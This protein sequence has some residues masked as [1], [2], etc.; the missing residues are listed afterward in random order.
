MLEQDFPWCGA[1]PDNPSS[2]SVSKPSNLIGFPKLEQCFGLSWTTSKERMP[3]Y[4]SQGK[5]SRSEPKDD[6][7][8]SRKTSLLK[9]CIW[10]L[11]RVTC[12]VFRR[13]YRE[14][15]HLC[16]SPENRSLL[17]GRDAWTSCFQGSV[18]TFGMP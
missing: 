4:V 13:E 11:E 17:R 9:I 3:V 2:I 6:R 15:T 16:R 1:P 7:F 14:R 8:L 18:I 12:V 5:S 10:F